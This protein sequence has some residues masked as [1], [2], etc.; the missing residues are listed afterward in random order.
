MDQLT[1]ILK[2][3]IR[4]N[5]LKEALDILDNELANN[6]NNWKALNYKG[7][8]L[9]NE[10]R[11][12]EALQHFEKA[13]KLD[14]TQSESWAFLGTYYLITKNQESAAK[15]FIEAEKLSPSESGCAQIA[16]YYYSIEEN[17]KSQLYVDKAL[18]INN[19]NE[20]ALNTQGLLLIKKNEYKDAIKFFKALT[21][22]NKFNS[23]YYNNLGHAYHLNKQL[24]Y[25]KR[26]L[27]HSIKLN[28]SNANAYNNLAILHSEKLNFTEAWE[29]ICKATSLDQDN[30][31]FWLNR[32]DILFSIIKSG[33]D[34]TETLKDVGYY[35]YRANI[36]TVDAL[37]ALMNSS[38]TF[39]NEDDIDI[40]ISGMIDLDVFFTETTKNCIID[41][42]FYYMIYKISLEII[43]LLNVSEIEES[44]YSHYT[45][46]DTANILIF[47]NSPFRLHS[48]TTANDPKEGYPLLNFLGFTGLYSPNIYQAFV[49][50]FTF[51][52]DSL[53]QF[54]L[55]GK[56]ENIEGSGIGI[57]LSYNY[58]SEDIKIN[59]SLI[60]PSKNEVKQ[61]I[62]R[63]IYLDPLSKRIISI[64]HKEA[65]VFYR[66]NL[67]EDKD[68]I[69]EKV[70]EYLSKIESIKNSVEKLLDNLNNTIHQ[71]YYSH[72][73]NDSEK[74]EIIKIVPLLLI[75]L[76][77]LVKHYDFKEEQECRII[78]VEPLIDNS[79][80]KISQDYGRMYLE[81]LPFRHAS[82]SY[83]KNIY[84]G[85]KCTNF[86]L[87]KDRITQLNSNIF[88]WQNEHP[89]I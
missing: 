1:Q 21:S 66:E 49:G 43:A 19:N 27:E 37:S 71:Y 74:E 59:N 64:G 84:F 72:E 89:F 6:P 14:S 78:Q 8:Y 47:E 83:L 36:S 58:F 82:Q 51:N 79:K 32:G 63:C 50:S 42:S 53:N 44:S 26:N 68:I 76:R 4:K 28:N 65:C 33:I 2:K 20:N 17:E 88:C 35:F 3:L 45:T 38:N 30:H 67:K 40:I 39:T 11:Y 9:L 24:Q 46:S 22:F 77:Y 12:T 57:E 75:H 73:V 62:F 81:Y 5:N 70:N 25:A 16:F 56:I 10:K 7:N 18:S 54:R 41:K 29:C 48:V 61:S 85:P 15:C 52:P 87:F 13:V 34:T 86:E 55:Y 69:D 31:Q 80:I 60:S 23:I